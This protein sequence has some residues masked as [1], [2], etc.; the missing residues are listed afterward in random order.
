MKWKRA[1]INFWDRW[2]YLSWVSCI[3]NNN[4]LFFFRININSNFK[5]RT[6]KFRYSLS[7]VLN[8]RANF[9]NW[10]KLHFLYNFSLN[11]ITF[12][13]EK[14]SFSV[15]LL[16]HF[17]T[18]FL[19]RRNFLFLTTLTLER[20]WNFFQEE[21]EKKEEYIYI[22]FGFSFRIVVNSTLIYCTF[23]QLIEN[24][25]TPVTGNPVQFF[26]TLLN[27]VKRV[28][29]QK[30]NAPSIQTE[31]ETSTNPTVPFQLSGTHIFNSIFPF[32]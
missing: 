9:T 1:E 25:Y 10:L 24:Q 7:D 15:F 16:R 28:K 4:F 19:R 20:S 11:K 27:L 32:I 3:F 18:R 21:E 31:R 26:N 8:I 17:M 23:L 22:R 30:E 12:F 14:Y 2:C 5:Q 13:Q 29:I 6:W